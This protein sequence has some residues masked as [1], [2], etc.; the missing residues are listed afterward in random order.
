MDLASIKKE[1]KAAIERFLAFIQNPLY[2]I[3]NRELVP[4]AQLTFYVV[5]L[6]IL[7]IVINL[8]ARFGIRGLLGIVTIPFFSLIMVAMWMV[9]GYI[10]HMI[11]FREKKYDV[12]LV[13]NIA[14]FASTFWILTQ[15]IPY[16]SALMWLVGFILFCE[17][18]SFRLKEPKSKVYLAFAIASLLS[19]IPM[20]FSFEYA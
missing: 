3:K 6:S 2:Q 10:V 13:S 16:L 9:I 18:Y 11:V 4:P 12:L 8:I 5:S 7:P 17:A 15:G 14:A 19:I 20:L 1:F